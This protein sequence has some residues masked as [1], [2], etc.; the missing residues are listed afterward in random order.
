MLPLPQRSTNPNLPP[1]P[2]ALT[3]TIPPSPFLN[4]A[5]KRKAKKSKQTPKNMVP[6][7]MKP[8]HIRFSNPVPDKDTAPNPNTFVLQSRVTFMTA[9]QE[10]DLTFSF[11]PWNEPRNGPYINDPADIPT[12]LNEFKKFT[13]RVTPVSNKVCHIKLCIACKNVDPTI[14]VQGG[15]EGS[16]L[17]HWFENNAAMCCK[18]AGNSKVKESIKPTACSET[19]QNSP[20][21]CRVG[22][23]NGIWPVMSD[24]KGFSKE[25]NMLVYEVA[26]IEGWGP[27]ELGVQFSNSKHGTFDGEKEKFRWPFVPY[28]TLSLE[29]DKENDAK[30]VKLIHRWTN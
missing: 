8:L 10:E 16:V 25:V 9:A 4:A 7:T 20:N 14:F 19:I 29:V 26:R 6:D 23:W 11:L 13:Q 17:A 12:S 18:H 21:S 5:K 24:T 2:T 15:Y 1:K 3:P 22:E 27:A 30:A 28:H